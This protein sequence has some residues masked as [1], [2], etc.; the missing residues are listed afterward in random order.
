MCVGF[1]RYHQSSS[2]SLSLSLS[3]PPSLPP[4]PSFS[5]SRYVKY[6]YPFECEYKHL[7]DPQELQLAIESNKRDRRHSDNIEFS[8]PQPPPPSSTGN[9]RPDSARSVEQVAMGIP[10][11]TYAMATSQGLQ[12]ITSPTMAIPHGSMPPY[13]GSFLIPSPGIRPNVVSSAG[14]LMQMANHLPIMMQATPTSGGGIK[15]ERN[16]EAGSDGDHQQH[17]HHSHQEGDFPP[18]A[19]R[20]AIDL[21]GSG[22]KGQQ[23]SYIIGAHHT[24]G[25]PT[26]HLLQMTHHPH[27]LIA[28]GPQGSPMMADARSLARIGGGE[29]EEDHQ[30]RKGEGHGENG[31]VPIQHPTSFVINTSKG[32]QLVQTTSS[33]QLVH[34]V[35]HPHLPIVMP[36]GFH[37]QF[38]TEMPKLTPPPP[39]VAPPPPSQLSKPEQEVGTASTP[40]KPEAKGVANSTGSKMPF[41]NISIQSNQSGRFP[42]GG[43]RQA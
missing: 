29:H 14:Q 30:G 34:M 5:L 38:A 25:T 1:M 21:S 7:S 32:A 15:G 31:R 24:A 18:P 27:Q 42:G 17:H 9:T 16:E 2:L 4:S 33:P 36:A 40:S 19:K 41:A 8:S 37:H 20:I 22:V 10:T 28:L 43:K 26:P 39:A 13:P 23:T 6:L 35:T 12:L 11:T 3:L